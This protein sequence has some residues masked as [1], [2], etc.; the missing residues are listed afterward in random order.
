[1]NCPYLFQ[2]LGKQL[3]TNR[4]A[5]ENAREAAGVPEILFHD[6]RRSAV[7]NME[8]AGIPRSEARQVSG[9]KTE[10]IYIRYDIA[11]EKGAIEVGQRMTAFHQS[12]RAKA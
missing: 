6:M 7:R 1:P 11:S 5:W 12:N 9:H 8:R 4:T 3:R 2:Y 10:S